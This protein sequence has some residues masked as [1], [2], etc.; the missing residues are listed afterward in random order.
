MN[1]LIGPSHGIATKASFELKASVLDFPIHVTQLGTAILGE[2]VVFEAGAPPHDIAVPIPHLPGLDAIEVA[3]ASFSIASAAHLRTQA[4]SATTPSEAVAITLSGV[5]AGQTVHLSGVTLSELSVTPPAGLVYALRGSSTTVFWSRNDSGA[6]VTSTTNPGGTVQHLHLVVRP[7]TG[8][9]AGPPIATAP[10]FRMPGPS[11]SLYGP[12]LAGASLLLTR[13][14]NGLVDAV[15]NLTPKQPMAACTVILGTAAEGT[16]GIGPNDGLPT[17]LR[18]LNWSARTAEAKFDTRAQGITVST[19]AGATPADEGALVAQFDRDPGG[20]LRVVDFAPA[21]RAALDQ[22][23]P[24]ATG[25]DLGLTLRV[26]VATPG[27]LHMKLGAVAAR[28]VHRPLPNPDAIALRGA[29]ERMVIPVPQGL[30]PQGLSFRLDGRYGPARL[31]SAADQAPSASREGYRIAGPQR[32]ARRLLLT[33]K[34]TALPLAR[35]ALYGRASE[36][37]EI[38][39][40]RHGGD[41]VRIGPP[42]GPPVSCPL[43]ADAYPRWHRVDVPARDGLPPHPAA[44]WIS[45][46][47]TK[48]VFWWHADMAP[49]PD[50]A[51]ATAD[52]G[53]TWARVVGR[54]LTQAWVNEVDPATGDPAPLSP[55]SLGWTNG[56]LNADIVG[57]GAGPMPRDFTRLWV[58]S[59]SADAAFLS[60]IATLPGQLALDL[61]CTRD[62]DLSLAEVALTYDPWTAGGAS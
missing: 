32:L 49:Q 1:K 48:G 35:L 25:P 11:P 18:P 52:A 20:T 30:R 15:L 21:A 50:A 19:H 60:A 6:V 37:G 5:A 56:T 39:I 4:T 61:H 12:A 8:G 38:L 46:Q 40:T 16:A 53:A 17:E 45:V 2:P 36:A 43:A 41:E 54:P 58:A 55:V 14:S 44:V 13:R 34:E 59:G 23:Y 27:A 47:A 33:P 26:K 3:S 28:Y 9:N 29:P 57:V 31:I 62:L 10:H 22:G 51:Q 24:S 7:A 42:L